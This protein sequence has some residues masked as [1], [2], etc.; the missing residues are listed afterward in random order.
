MS[1]KTTADESST[2]TD[3]LN[4]AWFEIDCAAGQLR[5]SLGGLHGLRERLGAF[6]MEGKTLGRNEGQV[7]ANALDDYL[8]EIEAAERALDAI[9]EGKAAVTR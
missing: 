4:P 7:Y 1:K 6:W 8:H 3:G 5:Y 2:A 9:V